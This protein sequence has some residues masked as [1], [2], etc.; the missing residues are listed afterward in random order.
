VC[1]M[2]DV[3]GERAQNPGSRRNANELGLGGLCCGERIVGWSND[4]MIHT[5]RMTKYSSIELS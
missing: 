1:F 3:F 4:R 5:P 2:L